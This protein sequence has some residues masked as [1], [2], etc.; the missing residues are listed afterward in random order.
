MGLLILVCGLALF[1]GAHLFVTMREHRATLIARFGEGPYKL[2]FSL[3]SAL[4]IV[5]I[6]YGFGLYRATGWVDLWYPPRW[7]RHVVAL[8]MWPAVVLLLAAYLP[9][10]IKHTLKHP[11]LVAVKLWAAAHLLANGDL[12]SI[13]LFGSFLAWAVY[14][15]IAVKRRGAAGQPPISLAAGGWSN[16]LIAVVVGTLIYLALGLV[17]H[18]VVIG[19]PAFTG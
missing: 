6:A 12:G 3:I 2:G 17:F 4:G 10:H 16:D 15:R 11:M 19:V 13:V 18:P 14:D 8:L 9:G 1:I 5:L 7:T